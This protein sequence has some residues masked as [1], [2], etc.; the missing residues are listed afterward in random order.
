MGQKTRGDDIDFE[1]HLFEEDFG[2]MLEMC[3]WEIWSRE[4]GKSVLG[5]HD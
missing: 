5:S 3:F 1:N 2:I 4:K